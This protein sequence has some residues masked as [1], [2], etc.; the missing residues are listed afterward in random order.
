ML[1]KDGNSGENLQRRRIPTTGHHYVRLTVLIV[2]GPLPDTNTFHAMHHRGFHR[3]PLR[4]CVF[5]CNHNIDVVPAAQAMVEN[6]QQTIGVRRQIAA[7]DIG[8]LV[9]NVVEETGVLV[10]EAVV[11]L[12]PDMRGQQIVQG[13]NLASPGQFRRHF[14]PLG[15]LAEHRVNDADKG[16]VAVEQPVPPSQQI[17]FQPPLALV[18][19]EHRVQH[20]PGGREK[21]IVFGLSGIP[22]AVGDFKDSAQEIRERFIGAEDTEITFFLV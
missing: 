10:R 14:Q 4:K 13:R 12:L 9:D 22:L 6:R 17:A 16:F 20:S 5:A 21:F 3:Q 15:V 18:F 19:T 11:I 2:A 1:P 7:H 8:L